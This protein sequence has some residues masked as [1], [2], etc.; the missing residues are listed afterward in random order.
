M[1][2]K[3]Q[4]KKEQTCSIPRKHADTTEKSENKKDRNAVK[5]KR[6]EK[7]HGF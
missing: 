5:E 2:K 1:E 7:V 4:K 6:K 3:K